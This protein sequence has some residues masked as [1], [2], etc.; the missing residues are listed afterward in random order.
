MKSTQIKYRKD[1][2]ELKYG[3]SQ[4]ADIQA[5]QLSVYVFKNK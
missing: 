1:Q 5:F 4:H 2:R 3:C